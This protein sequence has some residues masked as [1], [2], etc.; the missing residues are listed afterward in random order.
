MW[1]KWVQLAFEKYDEFEQQVRPVFETGGPEERESAS[2]EYLLVL[3]NQGRLREAE[4]LNRTGSPTGVSTGLGPHTPGLHNEGILDLE[5]GRAREAARVFA[6]LRG[7]DISGNPPG[8][9]ARSRAWS[10]TL[11]GMALAAAGDTAA[12]RALADSVERWGAG[13]AYGRDRKAHHYLRGLLLVA[14]GRDQGAVGE[15]QA[16]IHSASLGFTRV[17]YE[18]A[19]SLVR[20]GRPGE[21]VGPIQAALRGEL[22]ASCLYVTHTELHEVLAQAFAASGRPD[23]AAVHYRAVVKAWQRAD[24]EF[25]PRR[26]AAQRWLVRYQRGPGTGASIGTGASTRQG[27]ASAT[28]RSDGR[29]SSRGRRP[30]GLGRAGT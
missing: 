13:S 16:A 11:Q 1:T 12:V 27:A 7:G 22:D 9:Q 24:P 26:D 8:I 17:N 6:R 10:G 23:S 21:A 3:R 2:W 15:F 4:R 29:I 5:R 30:G 20:L 14:E 28:V 25:V 18:L 19:R